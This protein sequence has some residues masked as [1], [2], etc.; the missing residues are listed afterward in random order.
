MLKVPVKRGGIVKKKQ[1]GAKMMTK[2]DDRLAWSV[3]GETWGGG[4]IEIALVGESLFTGKL[5]CGGGIFFTTYSDLPDPDQDG[6]SPGGPCVGCSTS[7][8]KW[9]VEGAYVRERGGSWRDLGTCDLREKFLWVG[10][11]RKE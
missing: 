11:D 5:H 7:F 4:V 3:P 2:K 9:R 8:L 1:H 10:G 6:T